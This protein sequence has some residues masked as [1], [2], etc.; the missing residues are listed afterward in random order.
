MASPDLS[1]FAVRCVFAIG[2][3]GSG[4]GD[5]QMYEERI[6]L[7]RAA[8]FD[9]AIARA[10]D[11]AL[12]YAAAIDDSSNRYLGLTQAYHLFDEP[13]D[14]AE[15]FSLIRDSALEPAAYLNRFF[16]TGDEHTRRTE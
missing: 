7:W 11:E 2:L 10:E 8:S 5:R 3:P 9:D 12:R 4:G 14:G 15:V 13:G 6:T 16:D 1:W